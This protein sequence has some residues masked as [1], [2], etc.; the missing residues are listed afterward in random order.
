L[1][2]YEIKQ[3]QKQY[4]TNFDE[5]ICLSVAAGKAKSISCPLYWRGI[6]IEPHPKR[7]FFSFAS[8]GNYSTL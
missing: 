7:S 1:R 2:P 6:L 4:V 3:T 8:N 5:A